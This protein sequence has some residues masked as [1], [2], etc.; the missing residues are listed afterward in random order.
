MPQKIPRRYAP[1]SLNKRDRAKQ[2]KAIKTSRRQYKKGQY[3]TRPKLKSFK[4]KP[5]P[6]VA[7]AK[8][9][10]GVRKITANRELARKTKCTMKALEEIVDK[11]LGAYYSSGSRPNQ[12]AQ[13]WARARLASSITGGPASRVDRKILKRGCAKNS[14]AL[15][16]AKR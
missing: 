15:K 2:L 6:H 9:M 14:K 10:Y 16:L 5:S 4:S 3:T 11:G 1:S 8:K 7:K 12:T 13:S